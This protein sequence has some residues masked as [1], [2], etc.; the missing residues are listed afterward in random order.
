MTFKIVCGLRKRKLLLRYPRPSQELH[1]ESHLE[2]MGVA[3]T[4]EKA[5]FKRG[6]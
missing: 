1:T 3:L 4:K 6:K 5:F 2:V